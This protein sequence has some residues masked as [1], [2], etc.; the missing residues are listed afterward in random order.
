[1]HTEIL[2]NFHVLQT[3]LVSQIID[4]SQV[5]IG[6]NFSCFEIQF[7]VWFTDIVGCI[8]FVI[9]YMLNQMIVSGYEIKN[10]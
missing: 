3:G 4:Q 10:L 6:L 1:M 9:G 2:S 8:M 5:E 7:N